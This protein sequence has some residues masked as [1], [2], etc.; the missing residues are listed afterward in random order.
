MSSI[1]VPADRGERLADAEAP[2]TAGV[3][4]GLLPVVLTA[5]FMY[6]LDF[7][8][9]NVAIPSMQRGL[10]AGA[11]AIQWIMV[12]YSLALAAGL[13][14]A[15]R[16]GDIHGRR[17]M[18][19]LGLG[20]FTAAS[21]ACGFAPQVDLLVG[22]RVAQGLAAALMAP[23]VLAIIRTA[24]QGAAQA[25]AIALY[26]VTMG[27]GAVCGQLVGG[28]LIKADLFG[29]GWR[30]CFLINLPVGLA[31]LALVRRCLPESRAPRRPRLDNLGTLLI[32]ATL[33]ALLLPLVQ[34]RAAGW[35]LWTWL[36]LAAAAVLLVVF[37]VHQR[38]S[39]RRGGS[40]LVP[41]A[42]FRD[43]G[44][45]VSAVAQVLFAAGQGSFFLILALYLQ[46][47][48]GLDA[49]SS[50]VVFTVMALGYFESSRRSHLVAARLGRHAV[51]LGA[52]G[53]TIGLVLLW[54][55]ANLAG[56]APGT[57][58]VLWLIP[59]LVV[60]GLG[61]GLVLGPLTGASFSR[62]PAELVGAASGVVT[63]LQQV[64]GAIGVALLALV[65][66]GALPGGY[67]HA[68]QAGVLVL[69]VAELALAGLMQLLPRER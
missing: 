26:A 25:R 64:G 51:T 67:A 13:I 39:A 28:L 5:T 14:T 7:F 27:L 2:G 48:R 36:S 49:L 18:F 12:G 62:V 24:Y 16:L 65:F 58:R 33:V 42:L 66:Y 56:D 21:A 69:A 68:F 52:V 4:R 59:G 31:A 41:P 17:R 22:A 63:A 40:P 46:L 57:A 29:S 11:G 44:F 37:A 43:R 60:D 10:G 55:G 45:T 23:Q 15:G 35:P 38:R 34:G 32:A 6:A 54:A 20:L 3:P 1:S 47:G 61:M 19:A 8:I 30:A 53:M 50:G 9:V